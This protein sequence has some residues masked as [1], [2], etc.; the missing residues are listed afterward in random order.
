MSDFEMT[1]DA[2]LRELVDH[3]AISRLQARYADA[4]TRRAMS[5]LDQ[6]FL[7][8]AGLHLDLVTSPQRTLTGPVEIGN[9][10]G[11]AIERFSFFEF[12]ILNSHIETS[13]GRDAAGSRLWMCEIRCDADG[14]PTGDGW[15]TAYGLYQ[16]TYARVD[17]RWWFADRTYRSLARKGPGGTVLPFPDLQ[18]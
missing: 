2:D 9:F 1:S 15:S 14:D 8:A 5:E 10:I 18:V 6:L 16:D 4:I 3:N 12:V 13:P 7:P 11:S 17:G